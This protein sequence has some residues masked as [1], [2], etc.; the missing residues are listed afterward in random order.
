MTRMN[1]SGESRKEA[2]DTIMKVLGT[3]TKTRIG[4]LN[5][6][7][8]YQ[9][10]KITEVITEM[11]PEGGTQSIHDEGGGGGGG[12]PVYFFGLKIYTFFFFLGQE[13]CHVFF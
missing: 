8:L 12:L 7:A 1:G 6:Q 5:V 11:S 3:K 4:F 10:G 9:T 13:I 2:T